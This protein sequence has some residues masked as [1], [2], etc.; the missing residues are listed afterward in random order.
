[1]AVQKLS[2]KAVLVSH[3]RRWKISWIMGMYLLKNWKISMI[4]RIPLALAVN[5]TCAR[6]LEYQIILPALPWDL[7][8]SALFPVYSGAID[9]H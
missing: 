9:R 4:D 6:Q 5:A 1:V 8:S 7:D 3:Y 2:D